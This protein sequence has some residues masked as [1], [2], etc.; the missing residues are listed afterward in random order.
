MKSDTPLLSACDVSF[1]FSGLSMFLGPVSMD[2]L[3]G[4][5]WGLVG[6]NGAG[7]STLLRILAGL[8]QPGVGQV[9]L[10]G[11]PVR[12]VSRSQRAKSIAFL[13]QHPPVDVDMLVEDVVLLGRFPHRT[14]GLFESGLDRRL[15][16]A[17]MQSAGIAGFSR[18]RLSTLSG[19]EAQRVHLAAAFAQ[20]PS[21]LLLDEPTTG[22]DLNHQIALFDMI[23]QKVDDDQLSAVV[24]T[25]N[26]NLAAQYCDRIL[27]LDGG[28][29]AA[30]DSPDRVVK[31]EV[32][33]SVYGL[34]LVS[35][36][37]EDSRVAWVV[38]EHRGVRTNR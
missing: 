19:G 28:T 8:I 13:P 12:E 11:V 14:L 24:V 36:K 1:G 6:P 17:A 38:P 7:K 32:L 3:A 27:L 21:V 16:E 31:P 30:C 20:S 29:V 23:R 35:A 22:L 18:R 25:H 34:E 15:A 10:E 5:C 37:T 33:S 2:V 9:F 26:V 4:Q